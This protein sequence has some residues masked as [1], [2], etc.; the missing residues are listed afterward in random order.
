MQTI[1]IWIALML[2]LLLQWQVSFAGAETGKKTNNNVP[3]GMRRIEDCAKI[4]HDCTHKECCTNLICNR[5]KF[6]NVCD[7]D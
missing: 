3:E 7:Y 1:R 5:K 6:R 4:G 2:C